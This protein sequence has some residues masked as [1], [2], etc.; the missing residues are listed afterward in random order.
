MA[1]SVA[2]RRS[3]GSAPRAS[4]AGP[5]APPLPRRW[6]ITAFDLQL[7]IA[8][9]AVIIGGMWLRHGGASLFADQI[10]AIAA[11]GQLTALYGTYLSLVGILL[12]SRA[13]WIDQVVGSDE[14]AR[15]HRLSGF[16]AVWLLVAHTVAST[17][18][19]VSDG[20]APTVA[21][22]WQGIVD[23]TLQQEGGLGATVAIALFILVAVVSI[24]AARARLA[25]ETWYGI[26]LYVYI[27]VALGFLHQLAIGSDFIDDPLARSTWI[28]LYLIAFVPLLIHRFGEPLLRNLRHRYYVDEVV[29]E[30]PGV[31]SIWIAGSNLEKLPMRAGQWFGIRLLTSDGWWRS[32]PYSLSA[33]PDARRLRFTVEALGDGSRRLQRVKPGTRVFLE[34]PYGVLTG[35]VRTREKVLLIAGGIGITPLRALFEVLPARRGD[36]ALLY[37]AGSKDD[38]VFKQELNRIGEA[39]GARVDFVTGSRDKYAFS[40]DPL[41]AGG[42][43]AAYRDIAERDVY[44]CGSPRMME[45]VEKSLRELGL[46]DSQIHLERFSW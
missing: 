36:L 2:T 25:Y 6:S 7:L 24:R 31:A 28:A 16:A 44:L 37:R 20:G 42:L 18:A 30:R 19:L 27:A 46:P 22:L 13:P 33:G 12:L 23:F 10:G 38:L 29:M 3:E 15:L 1:V 45:R 4:G 43:R 34:G 39:R 5:I 14:A 35:A 8:G 11:V 17:A 32:N 40:D 26:H 9:V 41:S 21:Q